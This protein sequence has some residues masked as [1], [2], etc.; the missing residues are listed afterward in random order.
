MADGLSC[1]FP[2]SPDTVVVDTHVNMVTLPDLRAWT[3]YCVSVQSR[4]DFYSKFSA[5]TTPHCMQTEG[6]ELGGVGGLRVDVL[7][8]CTASHTKETI[9]T[10]NRV[11]VNG[12]F[13]YLIH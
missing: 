13:R 9:S 11:R 4:Y 6:E 12:Q 10:V 2:Q 3:W 7:Y 5:F 1:V 8:R